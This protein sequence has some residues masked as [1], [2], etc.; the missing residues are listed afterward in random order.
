MTEDGQSTA[1]ERLDVPETATA[2]EIAHAFRRLARRIHPDFLADRPEAERRA[3]ESRF[4]ELNQAHELLQG[5][6]RA[7]YDRD[8]REMRAAAARQEQLAAED[9]LRRQHEERQREARERLRWESA[10]RVAAETE[11]VRR[12]EQ[13]Y[14][15]EAETAAREAA[16]R[17][18]ARDAME[19]QRAWQM[20][21]SRPIQGQ[22][23]QLTVDLTRQ[24]WLDGASFIAPYGG[25]PLR[26]T[27]GTRHDAR[28]T[29][30]GRGAPGTNGGAPGDLHV[31]VRHVSRRGRELARGHR[32]WTVG[33]AI[34]GLIYSLA[35]ILVWSVVI[36]MVLAFIAIGYALLTGR[37]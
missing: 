17:Q 37:L 21:V 9:R 4:K 23:A 12:E 8:L 1:Y 7:E 25:S 32:R 10:Q 24:G 22:D 13:R 11:R 18:R 33:S 14:R 27:P 20:F 2:Q 29:M 5:A 19:A 30:R 16:E 3:A 28:G 15:R 35:A 6:R 34:S 36:V 26:V 31:R